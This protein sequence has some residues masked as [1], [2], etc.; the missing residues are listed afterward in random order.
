MD[1]KKRLTSSNDDVNLEVTSIGYSV[2]ECKAVTSSAN[3]IVSHQL[4]LPL[5]LPVAVLIAVVFRRDDDPSLIRRKVRDNVTP[6]SVIVDTQSDDAALVGV[7]HEAKGAAR[8]ATAHREDMG[9][10][11]FAPCPAVSEFP[12]RLLND[13][14]E[15]VRIALVDTRG[16]RVTHSTRC[17]ERVDKERC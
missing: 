5:P 12:D 13:V 15:C 4:L 6:T 16:D 14:E 1:H 11:N 2:L 10:V 7:G 3:D 9:P 17:N 8:P